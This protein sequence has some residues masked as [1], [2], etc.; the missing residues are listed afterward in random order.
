[1]AVVLHHSKA[2][3]TDKLVLLGIANHAGDGGSWPKVETLAKYG[4]VTERAV[5]VSI[6]KLIKTGE[7]LVERNA[8]G[9]RRH[10]NDARPNLYTV[11]VQC[12]INCDRS[13]NH[14]LRPYPVAADPL[15]FT[16][17]SVD[18]G[19]KQTSPRDQRGEADFTP[20]GEA[21]FTRT[22]SEPGHGDDVSSSVTGP[23]AR[24]ASPELRELRITETREAM[25]GW[26]QW[27]DPLGRGGESHAS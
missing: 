10:R 22:I 15:T 27:P 19:V 4:N 11:L 8:G 3:G 12:P 25:R 26:C 7:L 23:R 14:R 6:A 17:G 16:T 5:Q 13:T 2:R 1:M 9:T 20:R 21:D 24:P 18:D